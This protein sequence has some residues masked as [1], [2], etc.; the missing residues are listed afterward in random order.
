MKTNKIIYFIICLFS[1]IGLVSCSNVS[2]ED[3]TYEKRSGPSYG[4]NEIIR[5]DNPV[6]IISITSFTCSID[7]KVTRLDK[8]DDTLIVKLDYKTPYAYDLAVAYWRI[9]IKTT[10][11]FLEGIS[12]LEFDK[13]E[14][15]N[16]FTPASETIFS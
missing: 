6:I 5:G 13:G 2:Q 10:N 9:T 4:E 7:F 16:Y 1:F 14:L 12:K 11:E 3:V 8:K 15:Y